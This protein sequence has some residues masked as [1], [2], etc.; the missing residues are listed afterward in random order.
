MTRAKWAWPPLLAGVLVLAAAQG[1]RA[2]GLLSAGVVAAPAV[3]FGEAVGTGDLVETRAGDI[4][5]SNT[6]NQ[7]Q[8]AV[9]SGNQADNADS[10]DVN[11]AAGAMGSLDGIGLIVA[12]SGT[13]GVAQGNISLTVN[14]APAP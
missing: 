8:S 10:G 13:L 5:F 14:L 3:G 2:D 1:T 11:V 7:A 6:T 4:S 12:N 9:Q